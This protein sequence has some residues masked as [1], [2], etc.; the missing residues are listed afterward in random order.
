MWIKTCLQLGRQP[1]QEYYYKILNLIAT[2]PDVLEKSP[3][4]ET[5][6]SVASVSPTTRW[7]PVSLLNLSLE[8]TTSSPAI[9]YIF[10]M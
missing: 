10:K 6:G 5:T 9:V 3:E 2:G 8:V 7:L 1:K 4:P